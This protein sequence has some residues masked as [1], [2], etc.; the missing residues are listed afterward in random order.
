MI[1]AVVARGKQTQI[2]CD[3][4]RLHYVGCFAGG[5]R[6]SVHGNLASIAR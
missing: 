1:F 3:A 6:A 2:D 4:V 5:K